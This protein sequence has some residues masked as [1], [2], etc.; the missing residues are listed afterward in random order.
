MDGLPRS[1]TTSSPEAGPRGLRR[2]ALAFAAVVLQAAPGFPG[3]HL[4]AL[5]P[6]LVGASGVLMAI[7][8]VVNL[9]V[10][11]GAL[12]WALGVALLGASLNLVVMVPN[13][14]MPVSKAALEAIDGGHVDVTDGYLYK[15][16]LADDQTV[17]ALLGDVI[18]VRPL[19]LAA[20]IGDVV[21]LVGVLGIAATLVVVPRRR[22]VAFA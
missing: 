17:F 7:W 20:S 1:S 6:W 15:H 16:R 21:L 2:P 12:R 10:A 9:R 11:T 8:F 19:R 13:G 4:L 3:G 14:G 22:R 18:P 5:R